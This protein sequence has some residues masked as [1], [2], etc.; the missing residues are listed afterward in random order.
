MLPNVSWTMNLP[1]AH[2]RPLVWWMNEA[3]IALRAIG[4]G[5][6][7]LVGVAKGE[8]L[9]LWRTAVI[10]E[11]PGDCVIES[12][13]PLEPAVVIGMLAFGYN[14]YAVRESVCGRGLF[15]VAEP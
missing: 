3:D 12:P 2:M 8:R 13:E 11:V 9:R 10:P 14:D 7:F 5:A 1:R 4:I 6:D 15:D